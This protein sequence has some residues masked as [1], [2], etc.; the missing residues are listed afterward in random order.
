M[1][2]S[3]SGSS[4]SSYSPIRAPHLRDVLVSLQRLLRPDLANNESPS[5]IFMCGIESEAETFMKMRPKFFFINCE[6]IMGI[7][8]DVCPSLCA[9]IFFPVILKG[10]DYYIIVG[11][12]RTPVYRLLNPKDLFFTFQGTEV[13]AYILSRNYCGDGKRLSFHLN[14]DGK[15]EAYCIPGFMDGIQYPCPSKRWE[16]CKKSIIDKQLMFPLVDTP[17]VPANCKS[18]VQIVNLS[19]VNNIIDIK[20]PGNKQ[21]K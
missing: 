18:S 13:L 15:R 3:W 11:E 14:N 8:Q 12:D 17:V 1:S 10:G 2:L 19:G 4:S 21:N 6:V 7:D 16:N 5:H 20:F 9:N